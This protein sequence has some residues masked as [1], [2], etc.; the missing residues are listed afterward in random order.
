MTS[1]S[2]SHP[3]NAASRSRDPRL[4]FFR[5]LAM[6]IILVAHT[7]GNPWTLWIPAR[8]GFSDAADIFVFSSGMASA[9]AFG[10]VFIRRGWL[11]GTA[12]IAF[13][14][15]QVYWAHIIVF[16]TTAMLSFAIDHFGIGL[17]GKRYVTEPY[18]VPFFER[19]GE[20][21]LGLL[22][23]TYVPGMFD[24]LP[25]YLVILAMVPIVMALYRAG[26]RWAVF[27]FIG[28]VWLAAGL[29]GYAR[30]YAEADPEM[31]P[32][33]WQALLIGLGQRLD[34]LN[35]PASPFGDRSWFFNPFAWQLVFFTGFCFGMRWLPAPP[36]RRWLVWLAA[37]YVLLVIPF[38]WFK[39]HAGLYLP[40]DW[41]LQ[42][43][44]SDSRAAIEPLWWKTWYGGLR[45]LHYLALAY[46]AWV[47]VGPG[48]KRLSE[49]AR[50]PRPASRAV[51]LVAGVVAVVT[52]PY[53]YVDDIK[54]LAPALDTWFSENLPLV[55]GDRIGLLQLLH[56]AALIVL[57][58]AALGARG[59]QWLARDFVL[60]AV[61]VIR[62]VG[63][64]SL[65][66]FMSS[67]VLARFNGWVLDMIGRDA[68][69]VAVV[70]LAGFAI[71]IAVAYV[72]SWFKS[73]PWRGQGASAAQQTKSA[74][75]GRGQPRIAAMRA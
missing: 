9:L 2:P 33:A 45:Y 34:W 22:T 28:T 62:K 65:A 21:A 67:I 53:A 32:A 20:A 16:L 43:W 36:V 26:G 5:G 49:G 42:Q 74:A 19:T 13:R 69:K 27:A 25:M 61:P 31:V 12:R 44:V 10:A 57:G 8:F 6:F 52:V 1:T 59:R 38:A 54:A 14:V 51:L 73:Q 11:I 70:N 66:V 29:A 35:L 63:T 23:L 30:S 15:W 18:V 71:L 64:Q 39:I 47:A 75:D 7:P 40:S 55:S 48:G 56:L 58:W 46:L 60:K 68:W 50:P 3:H 37:G 24:I 72:V 17:P 4:D 41:A